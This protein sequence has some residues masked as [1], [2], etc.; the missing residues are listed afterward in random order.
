[1]SMR[2]GGKR[3]DVVVRDV[4][5]LRKNPPRLSLQL[6]QQGLE[7]ILR[8]GRS[9]S[10]EV[11]GPGE[12]VSFK[13]SFDFLVPPEQRA[14]LP[15]LLV[16]P[17]F[18]TVRESFRVTFMRNQDR[19]VYDLVE[20]ELA[21]KLQGVEFS[22][23]SDHIPFRMWLRLG[24][25]D[26]GNNFDME[27]RFLGRDI[28]EIQ[29]FFK[30]LRMLRAGGEVELFD[31]KKQTTVGPLS[32]EMGS[33]VEYLDEFEQLTDYLAEVARA[34]G[35][36][37]VAPEVIEKQELEALAFLLEVARRGE[38]TGGTVENLTA[39]LVRGDGPVDQILA[40]LG[41]ELTIRLD[42]DSYSQRLLGAQISVGAWSTIVENATLC[43]LE[44]VKKK[45]AALAPGESMPV[46][47]NP[48]GSVRQIFHKFYKGEPLAA[49][50]T[51]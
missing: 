50:V 3:V 28:F 20:F 10:A 35:Q 1:M 12:L 39:K 13:S 33:P 19:V 49:S 44:E 41:G 47:F 40:S 6:T 22:S 37:L 26:G 11:L 32:V 36:S 42:N 17:K 38:I 18:P 34:F 15:R 7:K 16:K 27:S 4:E 51:P 14:Q 2:L 46:T 30:A 29:K 43:E 24:A 5:A 45:Y 21:Q 48:G 25:D 8:S 31:L 9:G 23:T